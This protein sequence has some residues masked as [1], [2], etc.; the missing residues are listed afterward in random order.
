M[1]LRWRTIH[2]RPWTVKFVIKMLDDNG[3]YKKR[4]AVFIIDIS[5]MRRFPGDQPMYL[6]MISQ[7]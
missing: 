2:F 1:L 3:D 5:T 6:R 7:Q 4:L